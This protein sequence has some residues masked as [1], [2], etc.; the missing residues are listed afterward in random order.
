MLKLVDPKN[1]L[2][3][4]YFTSIDFVVSIGVLPPKRDEGSSK[5]SKVTKKKK[6]VEKPPTVK[7]D[8]MKET[9]PSILEILK[10]TKKPAKKPIDSPV[11]KLVQEP[12]I[13]STEQTHVDSSNV[14]SSQKG[15]KKIRKP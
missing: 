15:G 3:V 11:K 4:Q 1:P 2:L 5:A 13:I 12:T 7:K 8:V 14:L 10:R 6:Q 9:N